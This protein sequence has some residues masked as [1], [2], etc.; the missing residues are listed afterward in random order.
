MK[1]HES[2]SSLALMA[3]LCLDS[4]SA[5]PPDANAGQRKSLART[6]SQTCRCV[7]L[8]VEHVAVEGYTLTL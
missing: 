5:F 7:W 2:A 8:A 3:P 6:P 1:V 4:D